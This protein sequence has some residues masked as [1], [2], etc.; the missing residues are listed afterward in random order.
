MS[1]P[2]QILA[3]TSVECE[4]HATMLMEALKTEVAGMQS[5]DFDRES[6]RYCDDAYFKYADAMR[7]LAELT[8]GKLPRE[9]DNDQ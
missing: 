1:L 2:D 5:H 8:Y 9:K 3:M 7:H 6:G 4:R